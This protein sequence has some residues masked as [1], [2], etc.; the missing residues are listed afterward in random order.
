MLTA[1]YQNRQGISSCLTVLYAA[2]Y[3]YLKKYKS[4]GPITHIL[5]YKTETYI[6]L[7]GRTFR[8]VTRRNLHHGEN[9]S[10][11]SAKNVPL[12]R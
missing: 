10:P 4:P 9:I 5:T 3:F 1:F 7:A 8:S 6:S 12:S 2:A 11:G